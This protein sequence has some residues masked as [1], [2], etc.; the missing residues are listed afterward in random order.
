MKSCCA[1]TLT[2][3]EWKTELFAEAVSVNSKKQRMAS[4]ILAQDQRWRR[5]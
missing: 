3:E 2:I 1:G 4:L 5:A